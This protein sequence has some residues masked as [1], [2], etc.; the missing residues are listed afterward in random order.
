MNL[1][2]NKNDF[3]STNL[4]RLWK[5]PVFQNHDSR[6]YISSSIEINQYIKKKF[7]LH[8]HMKS[9]LGININLPFVSFGKINS[10]H[11]LGLDELLIYYFY[12]INSKKYKKVADIG[13]NIGLHSKLLSE[14]GYEVDSFEPDYNHYDIA[15]NY[16]R[17]CKKNTLYNCAVSS[18]NG[19]ADFTKILNNTT[20]SYL[21]DKKKGYGPLKKYKVDVINSNKL[22]GKYDLIKIDAEGSEIDILSSLGLREIKKIDLIVEITTKENRDLFWKYFCKNGVIVY[23]QKSSWNKVTKLDDL[24]KSYKE[25]S[26]FISEKNKWYD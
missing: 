20:G 4:S 5:N 13:A 26:I 22:I 8:N 25:G 12:I 15:K 10:S 14:L 11:L 2:S 19:K 24:P 17:N 23:S 6:E 18:F 21:I 16:L 3:I 9:I 7:R 1:N